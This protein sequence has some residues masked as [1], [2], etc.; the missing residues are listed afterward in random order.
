MIVVA[1]E[2]VLKGL[3]K[4]KRLAKQDLLVSNFTAD[5][6]FWVKQAEGRRNEYGNLMELVNEQGVD[7]AYRYAVKK[8]AGLPFTFADKDQEAE[9]IGTSQALEM[10]FTILGVQPPGRKEVKAKH[11]AAQL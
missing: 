1:K 7:H 11:S 10:F 6:D 5:P 9:V 8:Y 4:F 2:D 3:K